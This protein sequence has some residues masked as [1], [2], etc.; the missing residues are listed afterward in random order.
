MKRIFSI[1]ITAAAITAAPLAALEWG[2][3][4]NNETEAYTSGFSASEAT[5][6]QSNGAY[7]WM[8]T[9]LNRS[10]NLFFSGE[11][12]Y[13]YYFSA[14]SGNT[15]FTNIIDLN[16]FKFSFEENIGS[17]SLQ[18]ALGRCPVSD[19]TGAVFSQTCDGF[20]AKLSLPSAIFSAYAG[21]TGLLNGL[22][23]NILDKNWSY[24]KDGNFYTT[25][26]AYIPISASAEFPVLFGNQTLAVQ[27][28][29]FI[30]TE[31]NSASRYYANILMSGPI[32]NELYYSAVTCFGTMNFNG[33]MNYSAVSV[34]CYPMESMS[35]LCGLEYASGKYGIFENFIGFTARTAFNSMSSPQTSNILMPKISFS[36]ALGRMFAGFTGKYVMT[37]TENQM[38]SGGVEIGLSFSYGIFSDLQLGLDTNAFI[39]LRDSGDDNKFYAK[40]YAALSF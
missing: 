38:S 15:A 2:G 37:Y 29:T 35:F 5:A 3:I 27:L 23:V 32:A 4:V 28:N 18:L 12:L 11:V 24:A 33:L 40:L 9:A 1:I 7:L 39:D 36:F 14:Y 16:L 10:K 17:G 13:K 30:D 31:G 20:S 21:Y 26:D 25:A 19:M 22:N 34:V 8:N 6:V